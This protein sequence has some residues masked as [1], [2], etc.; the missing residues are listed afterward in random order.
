M[1][2]KILVGGLLLTGIVAAGVFVPPAVHANPAVKWAIVHLPDP[3]LI[4][5]S[6]AQGPVLFEHDDGRMARGEPCTVVYRFHPG[7][8]PREEIVAFHCKPK[9]GE[10]TDRFALSTGRDGLGNCVLREYQ[11]AGDVESHG[12]PTT[13]Q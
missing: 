10:T 3:T 2:S 8:G 11:F 4:A 1:R 9:W 5:G 7:K 12:V 6:F 13:S